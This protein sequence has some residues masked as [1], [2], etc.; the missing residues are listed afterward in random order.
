MYAHSGHYLPLE[1]AGWWMQLAIYT[2]WNRLPRDKGKNTIAQ[3]HEVD[4]YYLKTNNW[5]SKTLLT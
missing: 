3:A 4:S 1:D 5:L 2:T